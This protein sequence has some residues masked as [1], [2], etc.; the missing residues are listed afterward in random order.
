MTIGIKLTRKENLLHYGVPTGTVVTLDLEGEYLPICVSSEIYEN[1]SRTPLEAK[2]AQA[3]AARTFIA[4]HAA[5]GS[6]INDTAN[7]QAF[8]WKDPSTIPNCVDAVQ[9]TAGQTLMC[10]S[11]MIT[12]W[13]SNS[14][15]GKTRTSQEAWGG[16]TS[17]TISR[18][19]PWDIAGRAKWGNC[20]A[21]HGVG[22]SQIGAAYGASIGIACEDI[23]AFYYPNTEIM[24]NYGM[25]EP[26]D[27]QEVVDL[28]TKTN[29]GLV[30]WAQQWLGQPYWYGTC[31][32]KCTTSL[33][34]SKTA[35]YPQ[36]YTQNR[37]PQ[38]NRNIQ[39]GKSCA[40]CIGLIKGYV[41]VDEQGVIKYDRNTDVNTTGLYNRATLKGAIAALPE[42]PGLIVYK[43]GH[44]G[45][46]EG[47]GSV[48][49][50]KGFAYGIIRSKLTDTKWT[51]WIA[52]PFISYAGY[53]E[54]LMPGLP[55]FPY[56]AMVTTRSSPLNIW[57]NTSKGRSLGQ[58]KK[59]DT[60]TVTGD[61]KTSGWFQVQKN[62]VIGVADG[63]YLTPQGDVVGMA[64]DANPDPVDDSSEPYQATMTD[65]QTERE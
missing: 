8:S 44:V 46:Y 3:I 26:D 10:G 21:S 56:M 43:S 29:T 6:I 52:C 39:E 64:P 40:D 36:Y 4:S 60:L 11:Q 42:V 53:E 24:G 48:I 34:H 47:N 28:T 57:T 27:E 7:Y 50:A 59:G 51:H 1:N 63:Q 13:Y 23:L 41:W 25:Q 30:V 17:W 9:A 61:A 33:L 58:V 35:Q 5:K 32:Y 62:N 14:N 37:M 22:M 55:D 65:A 49:E 19:D 15:G 38:Y 2:K 12:A 54:M 45:V 31:C 18:P 20:A 16:V